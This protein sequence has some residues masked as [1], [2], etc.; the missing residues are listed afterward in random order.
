MMFKNYIRK[1]S[2]PRPFS[3]Q[4]K[5][6]V[7]LSLSLSLLF[8][9]ASACDVGPIASTKHHTSHLESSHGLG[10]EYTVM[11]MNY[12]KV[13]KFSQDEVRK[14]L[15]Y[16]SQHPA[17]TLN[18]K[19]EVIVNEF[20]GR[21]YRLR[22]AEG[23][24]N[25]ASAT[26]R[27]QLHIQ[28]APIYRTDQFVCS[29][30]VQTVLAIASSENMADFN[31]NIIKIE[32]GAAGNESIHFYN[33]NNFV[34]GDLNP[35]NQREGFISDKTSLYSHHY[36]S[37]VIDR[38]HWFKVIENDK[39]IHD[40]IQIIDTG[41]KKAN[42]I[43]GEK[44]Y[45]RFENNYP[46]RFHSFAP[47]KVTIHY[48]PKKKLA[49]FHNGSKADIANEH[50]IQT[51]PTPSIVEVVRNSKVWD[52]D[53]KKVKNVIG[54]NLNVSHLGL[55]YRKTYHKDELIYKRINCSYGSKNQKDEKSC[56]VTPVYCSQKQGCHEVMYAAATDAYP[57][58]YSLYKDNSGHYQCS[59]AKSANGSSV[60]SC[61][62][63]MSMPLGDYFSSYQDS[64]YVYMDNRSIL[65]LNIEQI[66]K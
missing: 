30:F 24:G 6:I 63:V 32:Y 3:I 42:K 36:T 39:D 9:T 38:D 26:K 51:L 46:L 52:I 37:S 16:F 61:N 25:W 13:S 33:R 22:F 21:P 48:I 23:E 7:G 57:E 58:G 4:A 49:I 14:L 62:Q 43:D 35:V 60:E 19:V 66:I 29:T 18:Q 64:K 1:S 27:G 5:V 59:P 28:Q 55:I 2:K 50:F 54:T 40:L 10:I 20:S 47:E 12:A 15:A 53:G 56:H 17:L 8:N 11:E 31:R 65:G 34:S 41:N 45:Q 44:M